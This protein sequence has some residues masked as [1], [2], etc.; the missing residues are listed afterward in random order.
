[1]ADALL[2]LI[3]NR[4]IKKPIAMTGELSLVG[5]VLPIGGLKEKVIAAKRH[6]LKQIIIPEHNKKDLEE[7]PANIKNGIIFHPVKTFDEVAE[8]VFS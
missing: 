7:I 8:I 2:S 1:M 4:V 5:N 3:T 6:R